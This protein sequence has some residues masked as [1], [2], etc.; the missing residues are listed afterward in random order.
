MTINNWNA[1]TRSF[2]YSDAD[3][4]LPKAEIEID[5]GYLPADLHRVITGHITA[6]QVS[7]PAAGQSVLTVSGLHQLDE[8]RN[9]QRSQV[10]ENMLDSALARQAVAP[11]DPDLRTDTSA[12]EG[13]EAHE[14]VFPTHQL[15]HLIQ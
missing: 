6:M 11:P 9:E 7:F 4:F 3:L 12:E 15:D 8:L 14:L 13:Q 2:K 5:I 1:E 10:V